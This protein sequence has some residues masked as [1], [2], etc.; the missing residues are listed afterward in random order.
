MSEKQNR[1]MPEWLGELNDVEFAQLL[2][3]FTEWPSMPDDGI[4]VEI[5][6]T[7]QRGTEPVQR[8]LTFQGQVMGSRLILSVPP[9]ARV[10]EGVRDIEIRLPDLHVIV[11][12][13]L[14]MA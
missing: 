1:L 14:S 10:P 8:A 11:S 9:G 7:T 13:D 12:L 4:S 2:Q 6:C 5:A 3:A